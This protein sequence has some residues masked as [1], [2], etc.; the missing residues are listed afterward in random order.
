MRIHDLAMTLRQVR[1]DDLSFVKVLS[2][3]L[4]AK[5][6]NLSDLKNDDELFD[7]VCDNVDK[8]MLS[9]MKLKRFNMTARHAAAR[10]ARAAR[11]ARLK[12]EKEKK[13]K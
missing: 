4:K 5:N 11:D 10:N 12:A 1:T 2:D 6:K 3:A 7:L 13:N 9:G 8:S